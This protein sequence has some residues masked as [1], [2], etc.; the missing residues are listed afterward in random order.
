GGDKEA[1]ESF[2]YQMRPIVLIVPQGAGPAVVEARHKEAE[3][4]R[5]R[6]QSCAEASNIFKA[7]QNSPI[8]D[9][10]IKTSADIP[11]TLREL[12]NKTPIGHLTPPEVTRQGVQMVAL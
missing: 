2:E 7:A 12:L 5:E 8:R 3:A 4:F 9:T 10:V 1:A 11:P 6:I